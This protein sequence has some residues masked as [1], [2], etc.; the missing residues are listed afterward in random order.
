MSLNEKNKPTK[1]KNKGDLL[2]EPAML[3]EGLKREG[4]TVLLLGIKFVMLLQKRNFS[5]HWG[6][7]QECL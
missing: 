7:D 6:R 2:P 1:N 3:Q 5:R 4:T